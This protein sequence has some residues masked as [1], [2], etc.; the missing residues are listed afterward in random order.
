[1]INGEEVEGNV[2]R[3]GKRDEVVFIQAVQ[4]AWSG[5]TF[6]VLKSSYKHLIYCL[7]FAEFRV[8]LQHCLPKR[9]TNHSRA[10]KALD[11]TSAR[12]REPERLLEI[13]MRISFTFAL[14]PALWMAQFTGER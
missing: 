11:T 12:D 7:W 14:D 8:H 2:W 5:N 9:E 13:A 4:N 10:F 3:A 6:L 1:M